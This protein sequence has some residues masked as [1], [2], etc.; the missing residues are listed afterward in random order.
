MIIDMQIGDKVSFICKLFGHK[1][2]WAYRRP[3]FHDNNWE[4]NVC[5]RCGRGH[6]INKVTSEHDP[7]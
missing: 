2:K 3:L 6:W 5:K 1:W 7:W 4:W